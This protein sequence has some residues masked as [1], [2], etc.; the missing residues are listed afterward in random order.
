MKTAI[1]TRNAHGL[2]KSMTD[3]TKGKGQKRK[4]VCQSFDPVVMIPAYWIR[5]SLRVSK[6]PTG[7]LITELVGAAEELRLEVAFR[8]AEELM[9]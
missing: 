4:N 8:A 9:T 7:T 6:F 3:P 2:S 1:H 5:I